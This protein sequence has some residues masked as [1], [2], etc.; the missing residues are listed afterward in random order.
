[1]SYADNHLTLKAEAVEMYLDE[2]HDNI[3]SFYDLCGFISEG[4]RIHDTPI[5]IAED[6]KRYLSERRINES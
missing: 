4:S 2:S 3:E 6:Y 5:V 1:M